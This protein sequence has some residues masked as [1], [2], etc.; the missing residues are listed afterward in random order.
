[1]NSFLKEKEILLNL[2][3][4]FNKLHIFNYLKVRHEHQI[5]SFVPLVMKGVMVNMTKHSSWPNPLFFIVDVDEAT[6]T[7]HH[8]QT[9]LLIGGYFALLESKISTMKIQKLK[10]AF[11]SATALTVPESNL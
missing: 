10:G 7:V 3:I 1:M 9:R 11:T 2:E 5:A 4:L 6:Q 8:L